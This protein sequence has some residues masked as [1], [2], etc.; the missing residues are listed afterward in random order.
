M[1]IIF[2]HMI[3]NRTYRKKKKRRHRNFRKSYTIPGGYLIYFKINVLANR[4]VPFTELKLV[5]L[6]KSKIR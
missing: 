4:I 6:K 1:S 3:E 2:Y 5:Q